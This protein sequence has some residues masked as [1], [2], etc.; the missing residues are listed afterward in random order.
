LLIMALFTLGNSADAFLILRAQAAGLALRQVMGLLLLFNVSYTLLSGPAGAVSDRIGRKRVLLLGWGLYALIYLGFAVAVQGWHL[1][2]LFVAYGFYYG[3][4]E[5]TAKAFV[6]D[7]VQP[8][9]RG[10]AYGWFNAAIGVAALPA[11]LLAGLLWQ[12]A[13][14]WPGLGM[15][16][17]FVF[18]GALALTA[19]VLLMGWLP[20]N[21]A[22]KYQSAS[23]L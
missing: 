23:H 3:L 2:L 15:A 8:D 20:G 19:A 7:L 21:T 18:G 10:T 13:G 14:G 6:A 12:G 16:A 17:P 9:Q 1:L 5:G 22:V 4:A 11:S